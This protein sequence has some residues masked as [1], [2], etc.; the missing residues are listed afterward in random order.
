[1]SSATNPQFEEQFDTDNPFNGV[2][3][4]YPTG[5]SF[6][7]IDGDLDLDMFIGDIA[8]TGYYSN[9]A[10]RFFKNTGT[11]TN[12]AF[13][14]FTGGDN[15]LENISPT[16][17]ESFLPVFA[18]LDG[19]SD[20]DAIIGGTNGVAQYYKNTGTATEP[21]F[22]QMSDANNPFYKK[23]VGNDFNA[24]FIDIDLDNDLDALV[25]DG[26]GSFHYFE[27]TGSETNPEMT[28]QSGVV[29]SG[30]W[31]FI[32]FAD[33]DAD[34]DLDLV[35]G[36]VYNYDQITGNYIP[37][38]YY[39]NVGTATAAKYQKQNGADNPFEEMFTDQYVAFPIFVDLDNDGDYDFFN[40]EYDYFGKGTSLSYYKNTG[41]PEF[42]E[43]TEQT[44]IDNPLSFFVTEEFAF[45]N[46]ADIDNDGDYD[47]FIGDY[48]S[49]DDS[50]GYGIIKYFRNTGTAENA[51]FEEATTPI[52]GQFMDSYL[53]KPE[54]SDIDMDGDLD[55][56]IA[57]YED[58]HSNGAVLYFKNTGTDTEPQFVEQTGIDNPFAGIAESQYF[59]YP[60]MADIDNDG[61][62]DLM[63]G[64]FS[65]SILFY[66]NK[67]INTKVAEN[68]INSSVNIYPNP[69]GSILNIK[70][71]NNN[72]ELNSIELFDYLGKKIEVLEQL[73]NEVEL[74][75]SYLPAGMYFIKITQGDK[76][77]TAKFM[78]K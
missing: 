21:N 35:L 20:F 75:V 26:E 28:D 6:I 10:V 68:A 8:S 56:L 78:K 38:V 40:F 2:N 48:V 44:G 64:T 52:P 59:V 62:D 11:Q 23:S 66:K 58:Y 25:H 36:T 69:T 29:Q 9:Q 42:P 24:E 1:T 77:K 32:D 27:N 34:G 55:C 12:P 53:M 37:M 60:A 33:L 4:N 73:D 22:E 13:E 39:K 31:A 57:T 5:F 63:L 16:Y 65:S 7:D 50:T 43:F 49:I 46:F 70:L 51:V 61:D 18:D 17:Y 71:D 30:Y 54:F 19:D 72:N 74:D 15:P 41:T 76:V 3:L 67:T 47:C 45:V 14:E